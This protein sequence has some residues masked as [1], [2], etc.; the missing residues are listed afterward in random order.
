MAFV[1]HPSGPPPSEK[2][3]TLLDLQ[4]LRTRDGVRRHRARQRQRRS[5]RVAE[6]QAL[7][8]QYQALTLVRLATA[9]AHARRCKWIELFAEARRLC[10]ENEVLKRALDDREQWRSSLHGL[11]KRLRDE[12]QK[13]AEVAIVNTSLLWQSSASVCMAARLLPRW[14]DLRDEFRLLRLATVS[15][16]DS[17]VQKESAP[18]A[19]TFGI[20]LRA[21][22]RLLRE[23]HQGVPCQ[24]SPR[25]R[26]M[27]GNLYHWVGGRVVCCELAVPSA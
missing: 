5:E 12:Q 24:P 15:F 7:E 6:L 17:S 9:A 21:H 10:G 11:V 14:R 3:P 27:L 19:A 16:G 8:Q 23:P 2:P 20:Q 13:A 26:S 25:A 18:C 1:L 22:W 4:R